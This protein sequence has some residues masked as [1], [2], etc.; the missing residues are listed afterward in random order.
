MRWVFRFTI[1]GQKQREMGLGSFPAITLL[2][3][4]QKAAA[5]RDLLERDEISL[6]RILR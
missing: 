5:A 1:K 6:K 3:A 2:Q 4:R